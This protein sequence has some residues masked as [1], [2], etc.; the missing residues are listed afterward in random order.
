MDLFTWLFLGGVFVIGCYLVSDFAIR[1]MFGAGFD[2]QVEEL[3]L[4]SDEEL[5]KMTKAQLE[6]YG[7][8]FGLELDKRKTKANMIKQLKSMLGE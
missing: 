5:M 1:K 6:Q 2:M 4:P 7:R 3:E 8:E